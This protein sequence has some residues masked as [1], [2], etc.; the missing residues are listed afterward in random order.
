[1]RWAGRTARQQQKA[2]PWTRRRERRSDGTDPSGGLT[3]GRPQTG[4]ARSKTRRVEPHRGWSQRVEPRRERGSEGRASDQRRAALGFAWCCSAAAW[5]EIAKAA[6]IIVRS[7]A[8]QAFCVST[9]SFLVGE[10]RLTAPP[11][12]LHA[13]IDRAQAPVAAMSCITLEPSIL[14]Q[15]AIVALP[16]P[17]TAQTLQVLLRTR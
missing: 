5:L 17:Q 8:L 4:E 9:S 11:F 14:A 16:Q 6:L 2:W 12:T 7:P 15:G 13:S 3:S 10:G 1:M